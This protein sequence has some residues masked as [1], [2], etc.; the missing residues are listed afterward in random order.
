MQYHLNPQEALILRHA[1]R[2]ARPEPQ[3]QWQRDTLVALN[4]RGY[5]RQEPEGW[6]ITPAGKAALLVYWKKQ[7]K[8]E[9]GIL[10]VQTAK[11]EALIDRITRLEQPEEES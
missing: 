3:T 2:S 10:T 4:R 7:L 6:V 1:L 9:Q 8:T 5:V 11:V